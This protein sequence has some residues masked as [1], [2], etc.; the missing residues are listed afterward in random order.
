MPDQP[1]DDRLRRFTQ[2]KYPLPR[3]E[4]VLEPHLPVELVIPATQRRD[5]R[6][7]ITH[8]NLAAYRGDARRVDR[9]DKGR[10][11]SVDLETAE[12]ADVDIL[13]KG[14][15]RMHADLAADDNAA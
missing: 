4:D 9:H 12:A 11:V 3:N 10:A 2:Q 8:R 7:L 15:A 1:A 13:G 14:R 6:V 5:K